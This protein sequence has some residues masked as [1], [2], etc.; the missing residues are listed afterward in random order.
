MLRWAV[1]RCWLSAEAAGCC[2]RTC[3]ARCGTAS[4]PS[5]LHLKQSENKVCVCVCV[6]V[7]SVEVSDCW[8]VGVAAVYGLACQPLYFAVTGLCDMLRHLDLRLERDSVRIHYYYA[9]RVTAYLLP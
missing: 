3:V 5:F 8:C 7:C 2:C 6:C 9:V 4:T 1:F